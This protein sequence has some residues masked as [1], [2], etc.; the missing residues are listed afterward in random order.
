[1]GN[2]LPRSCDWIKEKCVEFDPDNCTV[3][4]ESGDLV[5]YPHFLDVFLPNGLKVLIKLQFCNYI[6]VLFVWNV[7]YQTK[8]TVTALTVT[9]VITNL[10]LLL[11]TAV[12]VHHL[13]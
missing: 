11:V 9:A 4:T 12:T 8:C 1:M 13:L 3:T 7:Q 10:L 5:T 6:Y 2:V